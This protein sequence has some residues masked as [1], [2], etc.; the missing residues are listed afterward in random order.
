MF[1]YL[2]YIS[3]GIA[4]VF[5]IVGLF[6]IF[7]K[8]RTREQTHA[9][10]K[11][12]LHNNLSLRDKL[13]IINGKN[14]FGSNAVKNY[15]FDIKLTLA[16]MNKINDYAKIKVE[17]IVFAVLALIACIAINNIFLSIVLVPVAFMLPFAMVKV[18]YRKHLKT[19]EKELETALSLITISYTR[20]ANFITSVQE[21]V[22][23][24]PPT[25]KPFFED[26]LIEVTSINAS[27]PAAL[28]NLK[29][30]VENKTFQQWIDRVMVCQNDKTSIPS[31]QTYVNEFADNRSIQNELD[32]EIYSAKVELYM[33]MGFV[34]FTPVLLFFLQREA[35]NHLMNDTIGKI[36]IAI[37][38]GLVLFVY[39]IGNKIAKPVKFRGNKD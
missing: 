4:F 37:S 33:M 30:K 26:F 3:Y 38:A 31:L 39:F 11:I 1:K 18:K 22:D 7:Y 28:L 16:K 17:A 20:T 12:V 23:T 5:I 24:L 29:T 27:I 21:C 13:D 25:T 19:L 9:I 2:P 15:F 32:A 10:Q 8:P 6:L 14:S 35:F 36:T 34:A